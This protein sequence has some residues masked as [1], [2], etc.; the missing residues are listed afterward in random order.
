MLDDSGEN[1]LL[2]NV[3]KTR[4]MAVVFEGRKMARQLIC[5]LGKDVDVME[6]YKYPGKWK[7]NTEDVR[8]RQTDFFPFPRK[9]RDSRSRM[10]KI[11]YQSVVGVCRG[12]GTADEMK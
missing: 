8:K 4:E 5:I 6:E 10:L 12:S 7:T 1:H 3:A 11:F 2:P 9:L